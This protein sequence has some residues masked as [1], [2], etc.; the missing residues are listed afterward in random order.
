MRM[1]SISYVQHSQKPI[2]W[3]FGDFQIGKINL[4]VGK[5]ASGKTRILNV[6]SNFANLICGERK[7][8]AWGEFDVYFDNAGR[9]IHYSLKLENQAVTFE[10]LVINGKTLLDRTEGK[11]FAEKLNEMIDFQAPERDLAC[12]TR[13]DNVQHPFFE[14]LYQWGKSLRH[15]HFGTP[16]GRET[17]T[18]ES[19]STLL[20]VNSKNTADVV[21]ILKHGIKKFPKI[22]EQKIIEDMKKIGYDIEVI[23]VAPL[24]EALP[25]QTRA[26]GVVLKEKG[27]ECKVSQLE[28]SQ[29]MFRALSLI[30]QINYS[31]L[32]SAPDCI[33]IDDIGEGLDYHRATAL[34]GLLIEKV[35]SS[36]I[37]LVMTTN[38]RFIMNSVPLDYWCI[39]QRKKNGPNIL[40]Y[41][42]SKEVF[43]RFELTGLSNFDLFTSQY[44][45]S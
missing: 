12:V 45:E 43:D 31:V 6:I 32:T 34:V 9:E 35:S 4:I 16:L 30:I 25:L 3:R 27:L 33:L 38:D 42:N 44:Y 15:Y 29:G 21:P 14:D 5:N 28:I 24:L 39:I 1:T 11:I 20:E 13:R 10:K 17:F 41:Q 36:N 18:I 2:E 22:F 26:E 23:C 19:S 8:L 7:D 40:T 37:Q